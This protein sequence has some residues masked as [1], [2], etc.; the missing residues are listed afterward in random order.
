MIVD[1]T[2]FKFVRGE[3]R[4]VL[5]FELGDLFY[6]FR[7]YGVEKELGDPN[8]VMTCTLNINNFINFVV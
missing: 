7:I 1:P 2:Y 4:N 5:G 6:G 3:V 8:C